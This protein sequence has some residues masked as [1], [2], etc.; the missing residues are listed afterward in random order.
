MNWEALAAIS[1]AFTG[2]V[3][4]VTAIYAA[5][6]VRAM[7]EQAQATAA[8][9]EHLRKAN[10]LDGMHDVFNQLL[11]PEF[12]D[13]YNFVLTELADRMKDPT[14]RAE[15]CTRGASR[16]PHHREFNVFRTLESIGTWVKFGMVDEDPLYDFAGPTIVQAWD[17]LAEVVKVQRAAWKSDAYW[18]NFERLSATLASTCS[19]SI[20]GP[21]DRVRVVSLNANGIRSAA[22]KGF[23]TWMAREDPDFVCLQETKAQEHQLPFEAAAVSHYTGVFFDAE[24]MGFSG[25]AIYSKAKPPNV[26][27]GFGWPEFENEGRYLQFDF[28]AL[29]VASMY[30]VSGSMGAERQAAKEEFLDALFGELA[31]LRQ[32][33][34]SYII[35]GDYNIAHQ[36]IDVYNPKRCSRISGFLPHERAWLDRVI[37]ELGWVDAFRL[38]NQSGGEYTWWSNFRNDFGHNRG[39]R[40]DYQLITPDL[41]ERVQGARIFRDQRF[42]DHAP[43]IVDYAIDA[44]L[45]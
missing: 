38:V 22:R 5:R 43:V 12:S 21:N 18:E 36:E 13:G 25:V 40:I 8:Q 27:R 6:Q 34:R 2:I 19:Q 4:L 28:G 9:L 29:S 44:A 7:S 45:T 41:R 26:V 23:Y 17:A 16:A 31:R 10:Q 35:C 39:W 30:V 24:W 32:D 14:Y 15:V 3:I 1:T 20:T 42:S 37:N 33:G 11:A